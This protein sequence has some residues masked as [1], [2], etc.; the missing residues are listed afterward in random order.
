M[1]R[2]TKLKPDKRKKLCRKGNQ[3]EKEMNL[4]KYY[5]KKFDEGHK[6][7]TKTAV[8]WLACANIFFFV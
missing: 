6:H 7:E 2:K 3:T 8:L 4:S 1:E 5:V